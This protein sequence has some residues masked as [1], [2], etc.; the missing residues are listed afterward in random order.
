[1]RIKLSLILII[2]TA[3]LQFSTI[4][5]FAV[6]NGEKNEGNTHQ[7]LS[8][9]WDAPPEGSGN[10]ITRS[11][12]AV[13]RA[14]QGRRVGSAINDVQRARPADV[15]LQNDGRWVVRGQNGR[16]HILESNGQIVTT[17]SNKTNANVLAE[18]NSGKWSRLTIEQQNQFANLFRNYVN[19][20]N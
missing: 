13:I 14:S 2:F 10:Q 5:A 15:L 18:I 19:W 8:N 11:D 17:L 12:H 16:V 9:D 7:E 4:F 3:L 20:G 6:T 1:M